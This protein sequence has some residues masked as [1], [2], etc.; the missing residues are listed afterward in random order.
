M[1]EFDDLMK[2]K[3]VA[4]KYDPQKNGAP[5]VVA[6]GMGYLAERITETA[7]EAGVPVYEDDSLAT[8][9]TQLKLG[10]SI[11]V[12]LYQAIVDIYVYF[13]GYVPEEEE[14]EPVSEEEEVV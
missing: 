10:A 3:A 1:S 7:M 11:P 12:E 9:L 8:M 4:L 6:S 5:V 14:P 13:L 2:R